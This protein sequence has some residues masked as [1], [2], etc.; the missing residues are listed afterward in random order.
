M[1]LAALAVAGSALAAPLQ[2]SASPSTVPAP[3]ITVHPT[4]VMVNQSVT[5]VGSGFA[6]KASVTLSECSKKT[7]IVPEYP[8]ATGN[9]VTVRTN[10]AGGFRTVMKA[11]LCPSIPVPPTALGIVEVC[12]IGE[13][14]PT[15]VDTIALVGAARI[16][17]SAP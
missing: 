13:L 4:S 8:C 14:Q 1:S 16:T 11:T 15:G 17:V 6:P 12:Y 9:Q 3:H 10:S 2:A 5:V 7:W